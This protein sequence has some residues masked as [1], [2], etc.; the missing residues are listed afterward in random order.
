M[1]EASAASQP[2]FEMMTKGGGEPKN[3]TAGMTETG[4]VQT[5]ASN[6]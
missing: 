3:R 5:Q 6:T 4:R 1:K 2:L